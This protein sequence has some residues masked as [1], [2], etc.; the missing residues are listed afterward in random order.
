MTSVR[1]YNPPPGWPKPPDGWVPPQGWEPD[2]NWPTPPPG[3]KIWIVEDEPILNEALNPAENEDARS[4][5]NQTQRV[6]LDDIFI[7]QEAG[8]YKY[9]H[10]LEHSIQYKDELES[11]ESHQAELIRTGQAIRANQD[12]AYENSIAKGQKLSSDLCKLMLRAY[13]AEAENCIR[14]I[15]A[16][17]IDTIKRRLERTL[18]AISKLGRIMDMRISTEYHLLKIKE[19]ELTSDFFEK[20][21]EEK[22]RE[23]EERAR[24]REE[25]R[26]AKELE[27]ERIRLLKERQHIE[28][29]LNVLRASGA[30]DLELVTKL[31][32]L[33]DAIRQN[34]YRIANIRS[35]Y[36]YV[37]SN[38]GAFG[39]NVVKIGL[40]R[41]LEPRDRIT[42]LSGASV[43]FKFDIHALFFSED[44]VTLEN[45][46]HKH[47]QSRALNQVNQRKEFF[48]A[49]PKEVESVLISKVGNLLEYNESIE[50][51]EYFQSLRYWPKSSKGQEAQK[52]ADIP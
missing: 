40:T 29:A 31:N 30:E 14:T 3:W 15:R 44:A 5:P 28:N 43:P 32:D 8:I 16:G 50:S 33:D 27:A 37:I 35:G 45:E 38:R 9:H 13:N 19:L 52:K 11:V 48:F 25:K 17:N 1:K 42:E 10:P 51:E 47:F 36:V 23:R 18:K 41:R 46:L 26:A 21:K 20:K 49:S 4:E 34:D 6:D 2:P 24:L 7:L 22:E 12:F 39:E